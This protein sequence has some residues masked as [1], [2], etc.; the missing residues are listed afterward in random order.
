[1]L[2]PH[3]IA[4]LMVLSDA[5]ASCELDPFDIGA[6]VERQLVRFEAA[7]PRQSQI[8]VTGKGRQFLEAISRD[9]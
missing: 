1:M 9:R 7:T 3:E 4:A 8:Q 5:E 2:S 6:L